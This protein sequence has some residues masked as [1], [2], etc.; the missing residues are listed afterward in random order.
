MTEQ[1]VQEYIQK[2][3]EEAEQQAKID[4]AAAEK[5]IQE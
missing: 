2:A 4:K 5:E 1:Q 3:K